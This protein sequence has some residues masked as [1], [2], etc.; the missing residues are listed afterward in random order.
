MLKVAS[1][2]TLLVIGTSQQKTNPACAILTPQD[3]STL[4][5]AGATMLPMS[6]NPNGASC[7][8]QNGDRM[9]T[10]LYV[11]QTSPDNAS[12]LWSSKKRIAGGEDVDGWAGK[13]YAGALGTVPIVGVT[14]GVTFAEV[15][16]IDAKQK[17]ADLAPR[18]RAVMKGA[19]SRLP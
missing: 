11:K 7:M 3:V 13:A 16:V 6:A 10:V 14:K 2:A 12:S 8:Y 17:L 1:I 5:G 19:A 15:K 9:I 4:V 18:L